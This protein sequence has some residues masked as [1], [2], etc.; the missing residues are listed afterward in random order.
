M[1]GRTWR[2]AG[3]AQA[4]GKVKD[5]LRVEE[6]REHVVLDDVRGLLS[7]L[8]LRSFVA[9]HGDLAV[10]NVVR[11][12]RQNVQEGRLAAATRAHQRDHLTGVNLAA[13]VIENGQNLVRVGPVRHAFRHILPLERTVVGAVSLVR[14]IVRGGSVGLLLRDVLAGRLIH[15]DSD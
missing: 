3:E 13:D 6:L 1:T 7:E 10:V 14:A 2:G 8:S 15:V 4:R 5:L 12:T 9:E 11:A